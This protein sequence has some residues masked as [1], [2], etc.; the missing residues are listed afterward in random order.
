MDTVS[1]TRYTWTHQARFLSFTPAVIFSGLA[2]NRL[3]NNLRRKPRKLLPLEEVSLAGRIVLALK[4]I[5]GAL[6]LAVTVVQ[7]VLWQRDPLL[8]AEWSGLLA[9]I[10]NNI[11]AVST[12]GLMTDI[13][14]MGADIDCYYRS[15]RALQEQSAFT[16]A[17][18][19]LA[20]DHTAGGQ[21]DPDSCPVV[22][23]IG[24][25]RG[26]IGRS[27]RTRIGTLCPAPNFQPTMAKGRR[28]FAELCHSRPRFPPIG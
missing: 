12:S 8:G 1:E 11:A 10:A 20:G 7:T 9:S 19:I 3:V 16:A 18:S 21:S 24:P 6:L 26:L 4:V 14:L 2:L 17:G 5:V 27:H 13:E 22:L 25:S 15:R 23:A 28:Q